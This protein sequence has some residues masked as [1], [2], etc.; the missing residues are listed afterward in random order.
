VS[1]DLA[2]DVRCGERRQFDATCRVEAIDCLDQA[3]R[4]HLDEVLEPLAPMHEAA[5][6]RLDQWEVRLDKPLS[7][8]KVIALSVRP[9]QLR[10]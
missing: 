9:Q 8:S 5:C 6:K 3:N 7:R 4:S 1:L 2:Q 10:G